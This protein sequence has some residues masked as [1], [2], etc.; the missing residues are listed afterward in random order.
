MV[1][2]G[3]VRARGVQE[4]APTPRGRGPLREEQQWPR[5]AQRKRGVGSESASD[6]DDS[7]AAGDRARASGDGAAAPARAGASSWEC[8]SFRTANEKTKFL[9]LM[10][11]QVPQDG[12]ERP[13]SSGGAERELADQQR[14]H[15]HGKAKKGCRFCDRFAERANKLS[16]EKAASDRSRAASALAQSTHRSREVHLEGEY[17]QAVSRSLRN[18]HAGLGAS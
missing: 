18:K 7:S 14:C 15:L 5:Q 4:A 13:A 16:E 3:F 6:S 10:G 2:S 12:A 8:G 1:L 17:R 9:R 11:A